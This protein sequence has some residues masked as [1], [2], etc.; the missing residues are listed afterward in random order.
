MAKI[1]RLDDF[2]WHLTKL[3][4]DNK[5]APQG[6]ICLKVKV[7]NLGE[8]GM[9]VTTGCTIEQYERTAKLLRVNMHQQAN[10]PIELAPEFVRKVFEKKLSKWQKFI[11]FIK[12]MLWI[13]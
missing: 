3:M 6:A 11:N 5:V 7:K 12:K 1:H 8:T 9:L 13:K 4:P 10:A 2:T